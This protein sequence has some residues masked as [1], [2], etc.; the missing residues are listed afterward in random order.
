MIFFILDAPV[1]VDFLNPFN[2][3]SLL[4]LQAI[5]AINVRQKQ[6]SILPT[7]HVRNVSMPASNGNGGSLA[8]NKITIL[9]LLSPPIASTV[10]PKSLWDFYF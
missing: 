1:V 4:L 7:T 3:D 10:V 5:E 9:L 2:D 6:S 8:P